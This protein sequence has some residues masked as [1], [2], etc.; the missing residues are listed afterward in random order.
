MLR[1]LVISLVVANLLLLGFQ[2]SKPDPEP[3]KPV[4]PKRV[5]GDPRVP[6]I[7]LFS[8]MVEDEALLGESRRCF[9][10]GPFYSAEDRDVVRENLL[11]VSASVTGR[12]TEALVEKGYWVFMPP[13]VSNLEAN[14]ELLSL[15]ALG[16]DDVSII[17][18]GQWKNAISLGYFLRQENAQ[19]RKKDLESRGF[20][21]RIRVSRQ[22]EPRYWL[23]YEQPPGSE[24]LA[25]DMSD[26][27]NDFMQRAMPCSEDIQSVLE[28]AR[29]EVEA[30]E[31][32]TGE[33]PE[34]VAP[35]GPGEAAENADAQ[36]FPTEN[37]GDSQTGEGEEDD[38][39]GDNGE[40]DETE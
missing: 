32:S 10:L 18:G 27:P 17:Q 21:P 31:L 36:E 22:S 25:I 35:T 23:D 19:R 1:I 4:A 13:Y 11:R 26:R 7:H 12:E 8:E 3:A 39:E 15:K 16:L 2:A 30:A 33:S 40:V 6:T 20:Q 29:I 28:V 14:R 5:S 34:P 24:L 9:S 37:E 38:P